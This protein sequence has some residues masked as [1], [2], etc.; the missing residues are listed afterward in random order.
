MNTT[1]VGLRLYYSLM[2]HTKTVHAAKFLVA[3]VRETSRFTPVRGF[4]FYC[5]PFY[6]KSLYILNYKCNYQTKPD[7]RNIK[8]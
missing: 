7:V 8:I 6:S 1:Y 4:F 3:S 2:F 5:I